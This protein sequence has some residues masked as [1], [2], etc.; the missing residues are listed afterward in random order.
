MTF[1]V[2]NMFAVRGYGTDALK[3]ALALRHLQA[4]YNAG[5]GPTREAM[6]DAAPRRVDAAHNAA[7]L[8]G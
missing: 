1:A 8:V 5:H 3:E 2:T 6:Q 4:S 7:R